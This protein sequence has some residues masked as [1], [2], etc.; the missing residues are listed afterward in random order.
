MMSIGKQEKHRRRELYQRRCHAAYIMHVIMALVFVCAAAPAGATSAFNDPSS[1]SQGGSAGDLV[2]DNSIVDGGQI[3][4]GATAQ[5]V[6]LFRNE[7]GRP[8]EAGA[9]QLYPS[10]TVSGKVF[11]NECSSEPLPSGAV[12][13]VA[14]SVK[15]LQGRRLAGRD[16]NASQRAVPFGQGHLKRVR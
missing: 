5:V 15:G 8:I 12:C 9:I 2:P 11:L 10:S 4:I 1:R 16:A 7:S 14:V 6:V 3:T 13:A